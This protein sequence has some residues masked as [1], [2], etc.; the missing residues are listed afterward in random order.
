MVV[1]FSQPTNYVQSAI[2]S[3]AQVACLLDFTECLDHRVVEGLHVREVN[4]KQTDMKCGLDFRL[5]GRKGIQSISRD[6]WTP[7][8]KSNYT[9]YN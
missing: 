3:R 9:L 7:S 5:L 6:T 8:M 4:N 2:T 1:E